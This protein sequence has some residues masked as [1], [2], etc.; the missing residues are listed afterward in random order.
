VITA[1]S[2]HNATVI[3]RER[4]ARGLVT[5]QARLADA[6]AIA[7]VYNQAI[8]ARASTFET[9]PRTTEDIQALLIERGNIY[10]TI[11][12]ERAGRVVGWASSSQHSTRACF[13]RIAEFSV[14]VDHQARRTGVGRAALE[15]LVAECERRGFWKLLSRV[16][17]ENIASRVLCRAL[18]FR[19]IG[20]LR[21]HA[22]VDGIWH[23]AVIVEKLLGPARLAG[24]GTRAGVNNLGV[25]ALPST[26]RRHSPSPL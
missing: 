18:G 10:P 22:P 26:V 15:A 25:D 6:G 1:Q 14:Y 17:P 21:C 12:V 8:M 19:E 24:D 2:M 9:E 13:A 5:R 11:V 20:V 7:R 4:P 3:P 23:D 16:F